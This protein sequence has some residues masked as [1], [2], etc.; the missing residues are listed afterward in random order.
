M[1]RTGQRR[2]THA[3]ANRCVRSSDSADRPLRFPAVSPG[4]L[5]VVN[6]TRS[7]SPHQIRLAADPASPARTASGRSE[8]LLDPVAIPFRC[9]QDLRPVCPVP[10]WQRESYA[11]AGLIVKSVGSGAR[12]TRVVWRF[13]QVRGVQQQ[14]RTRQLP[15]ARRS[16]CLG[17]PLIR[18]NEGDDQGVCCRRA[19]SQAR[20]PRTPAVVP[21][22]SDAAIRSACT[23]RK[24][25]A[26][27]SATVAGL[28]RTAGPARWP[29]RTWARS[30][31]SR[32]RLRPG[33]G[34][35][36]ATAP[37]QPSMP[38][39][40][41]SGPA[42]RTH[43]HTWTGA[44]TYGVLAGGYTQATPSVTPRVI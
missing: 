41:L 18:R 13:S 3:A 9:S 10:R 36:L 17:R 5:P 25:V 7:A 40:L 39:H 1:L 8:P 14:R 15:A 27:P 29:P 24:L 35:T 23:H 38:A 16:P 26:A 37:W 44:S 4:S 21:I 33:R 22:A 12:H 32:R 42:T 34:S 19:A 2:R 11:S 20:T 31:R 30:P 28:P 43:C 6:L